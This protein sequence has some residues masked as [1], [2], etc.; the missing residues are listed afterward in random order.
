MAGF[1]SLKPIFRE[2]VPPAT[3]ILSHDAKPS[4]ISLLY[5]FMLIFKDENEVTWMDMTP[6]VFIRF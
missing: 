4:L 1:A 2:N 5:Q 6:H 3:T